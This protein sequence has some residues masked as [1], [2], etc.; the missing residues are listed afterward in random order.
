MLRLQ[1]LHTIRCQEALIVVSG[2]TPRHIHPSVAFQQKLVQYKSWNN[3]SSKASCLLFEATHVDY[4]FH[5]VVHKDTSQHL[6]D[7]FQEGG[8]LGGGLDCRWPAGSQNNYEQ[9]WYAA[10]TSP[11]L[12]RSTLLP[13]LFVLSP[14]TMLY[15]MGRWTSQGRLPY[16]SRSITGFAATAVTPTQPTGEV[17]LHTPK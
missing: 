4:G 8:Q 14:A 11:M 7:L 5:G 1:T 2:G 9:V 10:W 12:Q 13:Q 6:S 17:P 3:W 15:Q 16:P